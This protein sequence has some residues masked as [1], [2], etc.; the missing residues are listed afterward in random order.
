[1]RAAEDNEVIRSLVFLFHVS[2]SFFLAA[3]LCIYELRRIRDD[4]KN[5]K[6]DI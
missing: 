1:M 4:E 6:K 3:S 2:F 5:N